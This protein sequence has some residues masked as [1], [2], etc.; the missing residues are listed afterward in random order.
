MLKT[1]LRSNQIVTYYE[2][3]QKSNSAMK[4][5]VV[6][7][8]AFTKEGKD[9]HKFSFL[10]DFSQEVNI[11]ADIDL[12]EF[13][14]K[15][16]IERTGYLS[17]KSQRD[18]KRRV[19]TWSETLRFYK[20]DRQSSKKKINHM[21]TFV[22]LTYPS[23]QKHDDNYLKRQHLNHFII[24]SRRDFGIENYLWRAE[25]QQNGN[26]H[27][28]L[29]YDRYIHHSEIR[30]VWNEIIEGDYYVSEYQKKNGN[31]DPNSTDIHGLKNVSNI[32]SYIS[33]YMSKTEVSD[34]RR[35]KIEG[36]L[37]GCSDKI[38]DIKQPV[39]LSLLDDYYD[40]KDNI[41]VIDGLIDFVRNSELVK[42]EAEQENYSTTIITKLPLAD[43][44]QNYSPRLFSM[45]KK[46]Y[47]DLNKILFTK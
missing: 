10:Y 14:E 27:F 40:P 7:N 1:V 33:K 23:A 32:S 38:R 28:H 16:K 11:D 15:K 36:N 19:D 17:Y 25:V 22:T 20:E 31:K 39:L 21:F 9:M 3:M 44:I 45:Y 46:H 13:S 26:I 41:Y 30:K 2:S 42:W 29:L 43:I 4:S 8:Q 35:R 34:D 12:S 37:H 5:S 18:I 47:I 24:K 6:D